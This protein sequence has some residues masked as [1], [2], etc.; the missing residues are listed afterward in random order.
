MPAPLY[1]A[2]CAET[3]MT[4]RTWMFLFFAVFCLACFAA[5]YIG[6][7]GNWIQ[8][9]R[10]R[11]VHLHAVIWFWSPVAM[12]SFWH[13]PLTGTGS[14]DVLI[15]MLAQPA[16][17]ILGAVAADAIARLLNWDR[18]RR[19][20]LV[21]CAG[22]S[23][24]G[25]TL[26]AYLCYALL[27]PAQVALD[28]GIAY[29]TSMGVFMV[30]IFYPLAQHFS[31]R[32]VESLARVMSASF[33]TWRATPLYA[34]AAGL[35]LN[36][37]AVPWPQFVAEWHVTDG[38]FFLGAAGAYLGVGLRFRFGGA[39]HLWPLHTVLAVIHFG[40]YPLLAVSILQ[41]LEPVG[42]RPNSPADGVMILE[43][44]T[45]VALYGV[46]VANLF[47]LDARLASRLWLCNTAIFCVVPLPL[48]IWWST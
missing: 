43:A 36:L 4:Q 16:T 21:L 48:I 30:L 1:S 39:G 18:R 32:P 44:F 3:S 24:H 13:L 42:L 27:D 19:G 38:L 37:A 20:V 23:N 45:P 25:F 15:L 11:D 7:R 26:G 47:D 40:L 2:S 12:L 8:E 10:S 28:L 33:L 17:M 6:R 34:A 41:V 29:V 31:D 9:A 5:G 35:A 22:L 14:R 46:I